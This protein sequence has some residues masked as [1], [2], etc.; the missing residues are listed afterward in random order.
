[1][2]VDLDKL[3]S[4]EETVAESRPTGVDLDAL[5]ATDDPVP[6]EEDE[7]LLDDIM[8]TRTP[9]PTP[10]TPKGNTPPDLPEVTKP[11]TSSQY[12][13]NPA[14][15]QM[16][17]ERQKLKKGG[18]RDLFG[19][20]ASAV[21]QSPAML[22]EAYRAIG[23]NIEFDRQDPENMMNDDNFGDQVIGLEGRMF[24]MLAI[25]PIKDWLKIGGWHK[26]LDGLGKKIV[27]DNKEY[28]KNLGLD[29]PTG[30]APIDKFMF[31]L[32]SGATS[33]VGAVGASILM[34]PTAPAIAFGLHQKGS[35]MSE[36][37]DLPLTEGQ[38]EQERCFCKV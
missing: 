29:E 32:G 3:F 30:D 21:N 25:D 36:V 7:Q 11:G 13:G 9:S 37:L 20:W 34:G 2:A 6:E 31:N 24:K 27:K 10:T 19:G 16:P 18:V 5:F 17:W 8:D 14:S 22:G 15:E 38:T 12:Y 1:M 28:V 26:T 35:I 4:D 23:A 33:F